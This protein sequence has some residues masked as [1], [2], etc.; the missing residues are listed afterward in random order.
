MTARYLYQDVLYYVI[1]NKVKIRFIVIFLS[2]LPHSF[3][4]RRAPSSESPK[5]KTSIL[6]P[7]PLF[8]LASHGQPV[9]KLHQLFLNNVPQA[10]T[11]LP[12]SQSPQ[13]KALL[14]FIPRLLQ[15]NLNWFPSFQYLAPR[16]NLTATPFIGPLL[17]KKNQWLSS[18]GGKSPNSQLWHSRPSIQIQ[19]IFLNLSSDCLHFNLLL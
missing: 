12:Y 6:Y 18:D 11:F 5:Y 15:Q 13:Y 8:N 7:S 14:H 9:F 2:T 1:F 10:C 17:I 19:P 3:T 4:P 16:I